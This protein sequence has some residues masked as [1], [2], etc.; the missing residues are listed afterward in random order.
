MLQHSPTKEEMEA[1]KKCENEML[2]VPV[3][4]PLFFGVIAGSG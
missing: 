2:M 3:K 4:D 1:L